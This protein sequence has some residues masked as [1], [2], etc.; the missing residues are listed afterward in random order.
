MSN[1][2]PVVTAMRPANRA[3]LPALAEVFIAAWRGGYR[4]VVPDDVIDAMDATVAETE[5]APSVDAAD[6]TTLVA[7]DADGDIVGFT[8]FGPDRDRDAG[9][10]ASLYVSPMA[11]G[12]GIG[13]SLLNAAVEGMPGVDITLWVFAGNV[14]ARRLYERAGFHPDGTELTDPRWRAV[15]IRY[16]RSAGAMLVRTGPRGRA[17]PPP[18]PVARPV[19]RR[20]TRA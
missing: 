3:D 11:G 6:R 7:L 10:L 16:R 15:Q 18:D 19:E 2:D 13:W 14:R 17:I 20:V 9:Y 4:G 5:L 1:G 12:R 8:I